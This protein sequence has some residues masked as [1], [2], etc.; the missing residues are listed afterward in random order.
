MTL[1]G[2]PLVT[3]VSLDEEMQEGERV[4]SAHA[5]AVDGGE[6]GAV[7]KV[8]KPVEP[9]LERCRGGRGCCCCSKI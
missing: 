5:G 3:R 1:L 9:V 8:A 4:A 7:V 6:G 2:V